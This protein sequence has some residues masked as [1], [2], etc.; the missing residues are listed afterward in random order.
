M[1]NKPFAG[2]D[3]QG[4]EESGWL[5]NVLDFC[6]RETRKAA[7]FVT[8]RHAKIFTT[9]A[10]FRWRLGRL[11]V[12]NGIY[13]PCSLPKDHT[14]KSLFLELDKMR[15]LWVGDDVAGNT[16][17]PNLTASNNLSGNKYRI[18]VFV[19][20]KP[21]T[22]EYDRAPNGRKA[23]LPLHQRLAL[24]RI[25][26]RLNSNKDA[27][28]VL[29]EQ[30]GWFKEK[31]DEIESSSK[32]QSTGTMQ[33]PTASL[34]HG[35]KMI[36]CS[37]S[38]IV[39]VDK[40]LREFEFDGVFKDDVSQR[41]VYSVS[42]HELICDVVNGVS[43]TC[44][45][46]GQTGSGKT[47]TMFGKDEFSSSF[48]GIVPRA[49]SE[50]MSAVEH[51][52]NELNLKIECHVCVSF[53][54]VYGNEILDL[55]K[56]GKRVGQ[57]KVSA[58]R[59]VLDGSAEVPVTNVEEVMSL[60]SIGEAQKRKA[61]TA[62]NLRSSRAHTVFIVTLKQNC[63]DSGKSISSKLFLA[64][65]GGCEQ[66]K[67]SDLDAGKS[68]HIEVLKELSKG[69]EIDTMLQDL[70]KADEYSTGF[71]KSDRMREAVY[72]NLGLMSLKSC[73][74]ALTRG[75]YVP[76]SNSKLTM[77]LSSGLGGNSKTAVIVCASQEDEH[78]SETINA[79]KFGQ[80]CR[81]V[82]NTVRTHANMLCD[83][84][85]DLDFEIAACQERIRKNEKWVV[86]E[87]RIV[88]GLAEKGTLEAEGF[89]GFEVRKTTVLVGAEED[90]KLLHR[91]LSTRSELSGSPLA[92]SDQAC[93]SGHS[94]GGN[95]GFGDA[96]KYELGEI[97]SSDA[98]KENYRF[99]EQPSD[100]LVPGTVKSMQPEGVAV[101]AAKKGCLA[102][103]GISA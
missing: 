67:K 60:L 68:N 11:H 99:S 62:M 7:L 89:G 51:R 54:E 63:F 15:H 85:K 21:F 44:L 32:E 94:F 96:H 91:L 103:S 97:F 27:L 86:Q 43:A 40:G 81:R 79:F 75:T 6:D 65:L 93:R 102:Y 10:S 45:V 48:A 23:V 74:E 30:G 28:C 53:V 33:R 2:V 95:I 100:D 80:A 35:I 69:V 16:D 71:V 38:R 39:V 8:K 83:L 42:T 17:A 66:T 73:V 25:D 52:K 12:E 37:N 14:W 29:K 57:S 4:D 9:E 49:C 19:R 59:S 64:D 22:S 47:F 26:K 56:K 34:Q 55:L 46:Y 20:F 31:W 24:I 82:S 76:Y 18:S 84:M 87:Q 13:F 36:D 1:G 92:S 58:Q 77:L 5:F 3:I 98:Q 101:T 41:E 70:K 78:S 90:R 88:D 61:V 72:I 50:L